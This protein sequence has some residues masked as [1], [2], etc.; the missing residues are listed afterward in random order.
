MQPISVPFT[1][2][3]LGRVEFTAGVSTADRKSFYSVNF[4]LDSGS[5]FT[6]I[7]CND[8]IKLGYTQDFLQNCPLYAN[9]ASTATEE[10]K[11]QLRYITDVSL[12]FGDR[13]LQGCRI[14]FAPDTELR[15]LFG[16]DVLKYFNWEVNYDESKLKLTQRASVPALTLG[17]K[18][19]QIY[20]LADN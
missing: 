13:E 2:S 1:P 12:K 19:I 11:L 6:T 4:K 18:P 14:F 3:G 10:L 17:E 15:S 5:D 16:S 20:N 8:L 9:E 7:S